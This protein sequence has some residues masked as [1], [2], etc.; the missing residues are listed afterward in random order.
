MRGFTRSISITL[1]GWLWADILLGLFVIF[2][3]ANS[4]GAPPAVAAP[5]AAP[6]FKAGIDP[7]RV[8]LKITVD[9]A[10]LLRTD[11]SAVKTEADRIARAVDTEL[12]QRGLADRRVALVFAYAT[13]ERPNEGDTIARKGIASL[14]ASARFRGL[15]QEPQTFHDLV[16][17]DQGTLLTLQLYFFQ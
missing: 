12:G 17:G 15:V 6:T 1:G 9:G 13:H 7:D 3:A 4:V 8:E 16:P 14:V 5:T 11:Q 10:I 2:V